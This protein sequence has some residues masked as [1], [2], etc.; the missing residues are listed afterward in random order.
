MQQFKSKYAEQAFY[1]YNSEANVIRP[2]G[3]EQR[4]FW[5]VY[6]T[7]FMF[8]P[9]FHFPGIRGVAKYLFTAE[10]KDGKKH[11]FTAPLPTVSLAPIWAEILRVSFT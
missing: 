4:P 3:V 10:D 5:N 9:A 2:G 1:E 11:T 6:S 7:Q 8:A